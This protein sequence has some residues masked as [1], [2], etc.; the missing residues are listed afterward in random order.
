MSAEK[1]STL[2]S[3]NQL[4]KQLIVYGLRMNDVYCV[5]RMEVDL[6]VTTAT[7]IFSDLLWSLNKM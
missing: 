5:H 1:N 3:Q 7:I 4:H 6:S 2:Y